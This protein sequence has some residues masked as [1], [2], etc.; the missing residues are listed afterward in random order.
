MKAKVDLTTY[1]RLSNDE[2]LF[3]S[4]GPDDEPL[5][6]SHNPDHEKESLTGGG[7]KVQPSTLEPRKQ[8]RRQRIIRVLIKGI[9]I[10]LA[11]YGALVLSMSLYKA[12]EEARHT[13]IKRCDCGSSVAEAKAL[14]CEFVPLAAAWLPAAC[15]D[16]DLE[17]D[18]NRQGP[19]ESGTWKYWLEKNGTAHEIDVKDLGDLADSHSLYFTTRRWHV[20]HCAYYWIKAWRSSTTG[21]PVEPRYD[22]EGHIRHCLKDAFLDTLDLDSIMTGQRA[23]L[24][25]SE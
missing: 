23:S 1:R 16:T 9:T 8:K 19:G 10:L 20:T 14:G 25:S 15:R 3:D 22:H 17:D 4:N 6:H 12:T 24:I 5:L 7:A 13:A 18:F 21:I 11:S 2:V